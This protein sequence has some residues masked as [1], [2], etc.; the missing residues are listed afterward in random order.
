MNLAPPPA[1]LVEPMV[2]RALEEDLGRAGDLTTLFTVPEDA[3][4]R[5][6]L[7]A[8]EEGVV[9]GH[10]AAELAFRLLDPALRYDIRV[11]DGGWVR[12]EETIGEISGPA[13]AL[14]TAERVA[15]NFIGH[16]SG[17]GTQTAAL[18]A[19]TEGTKARILCTRKTIPGLRLLQKYAVR[20]GGGVNHRFGLND[21]VLVK[22]N[23]IAAAGG[24]EAAIRA[25]Q[26][27]IGPMTAFEVEV[28][29]LDQLEK[30]LKLGVPSILLD[31]MPPDM[32]REAVALTKGRATLEAS[33][34]VRRDTVRAI[35][36]TGVDYISSGALTHSV[37]ALDLG[38][39][40][41]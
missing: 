23:H 31:N 34:N 16:L 32:L 25:V 3:Q 41:F 8:R 18:V 24:I 27:R 19:E 21:A 38:L 20:C 9:A 33:G 15:L 2:R 22:D 35:A 28:D 6:K 11:P 14:L 17:V 1:L 30:A 7:V 12:K 36:A 26:A 29:T 13:R 39:D 40:F 10:I 4:A 5:A 37:R